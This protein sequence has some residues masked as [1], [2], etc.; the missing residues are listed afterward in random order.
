MQADTIP[1]DDWLR[2]G[3]AQLG[4]SPAEVWASSVR[5]LRV[6]SSGSGLM[7]PQ[8]SFATLCELFPDGG[9]DG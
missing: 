4:L 1:F 3:V 9:D 7:L 2:A 8:Q 5:D 6:L